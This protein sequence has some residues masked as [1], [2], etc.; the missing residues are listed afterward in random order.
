MSFLGHNSFSS[1]KWS[2]IANYLSEPWA[3]KLYAGITR[4][5]REVR[6]DGGRKVLEVEED[7]RT[8][9]NGGTRSSLN[10]YEGHSLES[11]YWISRLI[12]SRR[13]SGRG[14]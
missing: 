4:E 11:K 8:G 12:F 3:V 7:E 10:E 14:Y 6:N 9:F 1:N 5:V 13:G 2:K